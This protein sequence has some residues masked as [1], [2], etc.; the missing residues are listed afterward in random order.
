MKGALRRSMPGFLVTMRLPW[1]STVTT[2]SN[3]LYIKTWEL[4]AVAGTWTQKVIECEVTNRQWNSPATGDGFTNAEYIL[5]DFYNDLWKRKFANPN[6]VPH[7]SAKTKILNI[8]GNNQHLEVDVD[9]TSVQ[10]EVYS[11]PAQYSEDSG[12][13]VRLFAGKFGFVHSEGTF[14]INVNLPGFQYVN[15]ENQIFLPPHLVQGFWWKLEPNVQAF[16][17]VNRLKTDMD[18]EFSIDGGANYTVYTP[19]YHFP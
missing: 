12:D 18:I 14:G 11:Y 7:D 3:T 1:G 9:V 5:Q 4:D 6:M 10:L 8:S 16:A 2:S 17:H 13:P 15:W 19:G